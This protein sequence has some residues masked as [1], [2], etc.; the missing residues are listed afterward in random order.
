MAIPETIKVSELA[1]RMAIK[2]NDVIRALMKLGVMASINQAIDQDTAILVV[3]EMGHTAKLVQN[4]DLEQTLL[5]AV[6]DAEG[7]ALPRPPGS[8]QGQS[9]RQDLVLYY[10]R[11]TTV[12]RRGVWDHPDIGAYHVETERPITSHTPGHAAFTAIA[13]GRAG[14]TCHPGRR[15]RTE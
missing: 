3:E 7:E 10:I 8:R 15:S 13:P 12:P 1:Q 6:E 11:R 14:R 5:P 2:A 4:S 9:I